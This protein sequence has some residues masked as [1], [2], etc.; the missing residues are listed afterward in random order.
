MTD[1]LD[2]YVLDSEIESNSGEDP[3][4]IAM[5]SDEF[6]EATVVASDDAVAPYVPPGMDTIDPEIQYVPVGTDT[7]DPDIQYIPDPEVQ[8]IPSEPSI[9]EPIQGN[10][11]SGAS[12]IKG[13]AGTEESNSSEDRR[14]ALQAA[15]PTGNP[16]RPQPEPPLLYYNDQCK[17]DQ[18]SLCLGFNELSQQ[19][20]YEISQIQ[21]KCV[22]FSVLCK[23]S[24][25]M[26]SFIC[27]S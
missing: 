20:Y 8:Y 12:G 7:V 3:E 23:L 21:L 19:Y 22:Y 5:T 27:L 11:Q 26:N 2:L 16:V 25:L 13:G 9:S 14:P 24:T 10:K 17:L 4:V 6:P 18:S 15:G 1:V